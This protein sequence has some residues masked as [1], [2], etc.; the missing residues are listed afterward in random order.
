M[1]PELDATGAEA[2]YDLLASVAEQVPEIITVDM[3]D[4]DF[5]DSSGL[6]TLAR[7]QRLV[8][9]NHGELRAALGDSPV[10]RIFQLTGMDEVMTV[11]LDVRQSLSAGKSREA[12]APPHGSQ[13]TSG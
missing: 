11:F 3:T 13:S 2:F 5:C 6:N 1:P 4:T 12:L 8:L 10:Q 9:A 7:A